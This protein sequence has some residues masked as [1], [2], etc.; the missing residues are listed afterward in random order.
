[1]KL[2]DSMTMKGECHR[3]RLTSL[4][5]SLWEK[6][7]RRL[8]TFVFLSPFVFWI[9]ISLSLVFNCPGV[10][11]FRNVATFSRRQIANVGVCLVKFCWHTLARYPNIRANS[12]EASSSACETLPEMYEA[13]LLYEN[14]TVRFQCC[15]PPFVS[16]PVSCSRKFCPIFPPNKIIQIGSFSISFHCDFSVLG[17]VRISMILKKE[18]YSLYCNIKVLGNV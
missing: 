18:D 3:V 7:K 9:S 16:I 1:M 15:L 10:I 4:C 12:D 2:G 17:N 8:I 5:N 14:W 6:K 11:D 13:R